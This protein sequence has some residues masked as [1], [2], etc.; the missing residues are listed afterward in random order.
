MDMLEL[1]AARIETS[2]YLL[3]KQEMM[4]WALEDLQ[5]GLRTALAGPQFAP[6]IQVHAQVSLGAVFRYGPL[7]HEIKHIR[8]SFLLADIGR[9]P[10]AFVDYMGAGYDAALDPV[11][12]AVARKAQMAFVQV[13][14]RWTPGGLRALLLDAGA[15]ARQAMAA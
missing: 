15:L 11:K 6:G 8:P 1:L 10:V 9:F 2:D 4:N 3:R 7:Y 12:R 14:E 13:P 5:E